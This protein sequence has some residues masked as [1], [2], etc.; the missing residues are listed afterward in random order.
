MH[1]ANYIGKKSRGKDPEKSNKRKEKLT[2]VKKKRERLTAKE[3]KTRIAC[4]YTHTHK[5]GQALLFSQLGGR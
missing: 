5:G 4:T 2:R 3:R 1:S